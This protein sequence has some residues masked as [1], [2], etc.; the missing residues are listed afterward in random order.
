M[1]MRKW[2][3][4]PILTTL[5]FISVLT[6]DN[7]SYASSNDEAVLCGP[8]NSAYKN[9]EL[10]YNFFSDGINPFMT[11]D[12]ASNAELRNIYNKA[13][14]NYNRS[15]Q[16]LSDSIINGQHHNI[17][18]S[19]DLNEASDKLNKLKGEIIYIEQKNSRRNAS[20]YI[21]IMINIIENLPS[22]I[23]KYDLLIN[24]KE[25]EQ[26]TLCSNAFKRIALP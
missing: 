22:W 26:R 9:A 2:I 23:E 8:L 4:L 15:I 7:Y 6:C 24:K 20:E 5:G 17:T 25:I 16:N 11:R 1:S 21:D 12:E 18:F 10:A 14:N 13:R 19:S 3:F